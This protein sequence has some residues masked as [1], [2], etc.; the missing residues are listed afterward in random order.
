M[1]LIIRADDLGFSEAV[2]YGIYKSVTD[3]M[4]RNV[5]LMP[6][7]EFAKH[8]IDLLKD[9]DIAIGQHTNICIGKPVSDPA[10][11]P[12]LVN[13]N[14]EFYSSKEI[15]QR[16]QD[17]IIFDEAVIEI[18]AQLQRF[19]ELCGKQPDYFEGHA[20]YSKVFFKALEYVADKY[21]L[22]YCNPMDPIWCEKYSIYG[23]DMY[24]MDEHGLYDPVQY[25]FENEAN[26]HD[27]FPTVLIFHPGYLD[28][29]VLD[30]SSYTLIRPMECEFLCSEKLKIWIQEHSIS[31]HDFREFG[32]NRHD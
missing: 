5:G 22:L 31:L 12:S 19:Y 28:Q 2:N 11:I 6:N 13:E 24:H 20:I 9:S 10:L 4:V 7:M 27:D 32:G 16:K 8:G 1:K 29:F 18:E 21:H 14:Q 3:G 26:L 30:H 17:E 23:A 25:L 15:R